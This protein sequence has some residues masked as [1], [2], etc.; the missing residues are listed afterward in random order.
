MVETAEYNRLVHIT[1]IRKEG[2]DF[3]FK[4]KQF[5]LATELMF[6]TY[7]VVHESKFGCFKK[8][9]YQHGYSCFFTSTV[10]TTINAVVGY[11]PKS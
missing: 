6:N 10:W 7:N 2:W 1:T 9:L 3:P 5:H 11:E 4:C 8:I